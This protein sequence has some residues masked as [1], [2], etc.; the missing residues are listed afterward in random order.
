MKKWL[1]VPA[2]LGVVAMALAGP[3]SASPPPVTITE[4]HSSPFI[5]SPVASP[6]ITG[7]YCTYNTSYYKRYLDPQSDYLYVKGYESGCTRANLSVTINLLQNG[8]FY[9]QLAQ[10]S[11]ANNTQCVAPSQTIINC[12][13]MGQHYTVRVIGSHLYNTETVDYNFDACF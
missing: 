6:N 1:L 9:S 3:G 11:C 2:I 13:A 8:N 4:S 5:S 12:F 7:E 10:L